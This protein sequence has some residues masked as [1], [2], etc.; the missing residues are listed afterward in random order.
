[1]TP[2]VSVV[3]I[4]FNQAAFLE[5][6]LKGFLMQKT[7]FP[8]EILVHDDCSTDGTTEILRQYAEKY[9]DIIE[10]LHYSYPI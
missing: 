7:D 2:K 8:L 10:S 1:M 4:T 9:P 6:A 5:D 3:S